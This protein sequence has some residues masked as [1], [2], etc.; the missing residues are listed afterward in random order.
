MA[1]SSTSFKEGNKAA[2]KSPKVVLR[3]FREMLSNAENDDNI[4]SFQDACIS[5]KWRSSK[6][7]YWT[8]KIPVFETLKKDIQDI[9]VSRI[10]KKALN[11][12]FNATASIWR[13]KQL[14]EI[15]EST[16]NLTNNGNSFEPPKISFE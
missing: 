4:L 16:K 9:I 10:N 8:K 15:D 14:G 1:L 6:V 2:S 5:I 12:K 3:K 11:N 7:A 13:M